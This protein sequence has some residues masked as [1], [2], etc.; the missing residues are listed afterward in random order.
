M[1]EAFARLRDQDDISFVRGIIAAVR[2]LILSVV[3]FLSGISAL[4]FET[5]WLR[6]SG[7]AFGNSIWAAALI[8]SSFMAGLALGTAIA[9]SS[10]LRIRPLK[11]YAALEVAVALFG[12]TIVFALPIVGEL[13][14][15]LFQTLWNHQTI[16]LALRV[17]FSFVL[18]L[19]P[20]TAMGLTLPVVLEDRILSHDD[21]GRT[22]G[23][24]YGFN[25]L[26]AVAGALIGELFLI[27]A[28]GLWGTSL[29]AGLLNCVAAA[30]ALFLTRIEPAAENSP[31]QSRWLRLDYRLPW[32]PLVISFGA[33]CILLA[34]EVVWFRF[35]RLYVASSATAFSL[36][37][38]IVLAG[39]GLGG[40]VSGAFSKKMRQSALPLLLVA[41]AILTL[42]CYILFPVPKLGE[43]EKNFYLE[44][45][46][47]IAL[48][49]IALMFPVAFLSGVLFP[50]IAARVQENVPSR[51]NSLGI[52]TL[53]NTAGA[54]IGPMLAGFVLLPKL[55][56][57]SSL[58]ICAIGY[59]LLCLTISRADNWSPKHPT[60]LALVG[61]YVLFVASV[62]LFPFHRDEMHFANARRL[63]ESEE[64][65]LVKKI[66]GP[67]G[68][69][70]LLR[71]DLFGLPY[72]YRLMTDGFSMSATNPP[73]QRYMRLFAYLPLALHPQPQSAL[74]IAFGCGVT[75]D[76]LTHDVDLEHIDIV[77]ISKEAFDLADDYRGAGYLNS[78]RDPRVTAIVQ[79]GR[80]FLQ[81]SPQRYDIITSEPP[82]PKVLGSVN[83]YTEQFF[84]LMSDRLRDGG[85]ATFWLPVYQ[86]NVDEAKAILHAFHDAFPNCVIWSSSDEEWIMMG[87]KGAPHQIDPE[88]IRKLWSFSSTRTDLARIGIE[89]PEQL[90]ALFVMDGDE[91]DRITNGTKPLTDFYPKR[92][93]DVT[94]ED[95]SIH[96]FTGGYMQAT[97]AARRLRSSR[98]IQEILP[99]TMTPELEPFLAIREMRY[100]AG[101]SETNW[102]AELDI[103]L[104]GSRLREPVLETLET[105]SFR[106]A[107]VEKAADDLQPPPTEV[108]RDLIAA[109][110]ARR[111]Y[112]GA[113][114]LLED[115]RT[116]NAAN[117]DDILLLT[118]L[119]C[120][121]SE[122]AKAESIATVTT[123][124]QHPFVKWLWGKL[125]AEYGFRPPGSD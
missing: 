9:A 66:E 19:I 123:D 80:F 10:K 125:Q 31:A 105:N 78:L 32:R 69:W 85:M 116:R 91:I 48:L 39:I 117:R 72:Y 59:G 81:A 8:L 18:L 63:Y 79:D 76:A 11:F 42:L 57:Q 55:G 62:A 54:A 36:M 60:G 100:R 86:L 52:T 71:R 102:L 37:L 98:L 111:D 109:A 16:L 65:H 23:L 82:P 104:R 50:A 14:R 99:E 68:T 113:I 122:V 77:D 40:A 30:I 89:V 2:L 84:S 22:L 13:L 73:N 124:R 95:K 7:L 33:G 17:L 96:E 67:T 1:P 5:L 92:L 43:G 35:L 15:P 12:C 45:W 21:F 90:A 56:F 49:S 74:L 4:V 119:Y 106:I 26:G 83:L 107:L 94:A 118:Y 29:A 46:P 101:L 112:H 38:A 121:N 110:L 108:L 20:T 27:K 64:Q 53:F 6:L 44:S 87:I 120:L 88:R 47:Q 58:I 51:M 75:A 34:L 93:G 41:A 115:K 3:L 97:S 103:H 25:T 114:R 24:L 70:Q 61:L 28:F